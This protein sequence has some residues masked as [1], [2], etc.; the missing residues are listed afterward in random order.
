MRYLLA[1]I[2]LVLGLTSCGKAPETGSGTLSERQRDS[3][4]AETR[5]PGS[6]AIKRAYDLSDSARARN[7]RLEKTR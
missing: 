3:T 1:L 5:L 6:G 7:T 2:I 4:L